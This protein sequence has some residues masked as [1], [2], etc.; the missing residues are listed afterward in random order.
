MILYFVLSPFVH[1]EAKNPNKQPEVCNGPSKTMSLYF[2]F[3][4]DVMSAILW[5]K[6]NEKRFVTTKADWWL[7]K[8]KYLKLS[9]GSVNALNM[10][11]TSVRWDMQAAWSTI[12]TLTVLLSLAGAS[13]LQSNTE[14]L[15]ILLK[16]RVIVREYKQMLDIESSLMELAY[17]LSQRVNL[18]SKFEWTLLEN[19]KSVIKKYQSAWLL[20]ETNLSNMPN[21]TLADILTDMIMMNAY[22]KHFILYNGWL[23]NFKWCMWNYADSRYWSTECN[24]VAI[25]QFD[26]KAIK[27]L[28]DDYKWLWM[29]WA[30][31]QYALN[32]KSTISKWAN[33]NKNTVKSAMSDVKAAIKRLGSSLGFSNWDKSSEN[34]NRCDM[35]EYEMAQLRAYRWGNWSCNTWLANVNFGGSA[36][37]DVKKFIQEKKSQKSMKEEIPTSQKWWRKSVRKENKEYFKYI[38]SKIKE[39]RK[40]DE[41]QTVWREMYGEWEIFSVD[42]SGWFNDTLVD[43]YTWM[44]SDYQQS[45]ENAISSDIS[46]ELV[47]IKWLLD[48]IDTAREEMATLKKDLE[49]I[50]NYQCKS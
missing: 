17:F 13:V 20:K 18:I 33:N 40:T 29:F 30:C 12:S 43:L 50:A 31:N 37:N 38:K 25:L 9:D 26:E 16:D 44:M 47:M 27:Q 2:Q 45:Y 48:Q 23:G 1:V 11:A 36:I 41:K 7:F 42:Y 15:R 8:E 5:S 39:A 28:H 4:N 21:I 19:L 24:W 35:S 22:M 14:W 10:I 49:D 6:I 34:S 46:Y 3:Q 32:F